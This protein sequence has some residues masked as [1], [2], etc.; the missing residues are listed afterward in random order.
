MPVPVRKQIK[1]YIA[2]NPFA[3]ATAAELVTECA[4]NG[5]RERRVDR[6][7]AR[8]VANNV[9]TKSGDDYTIT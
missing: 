2:A 4:E 9:L 1:D 3:T 6:V 5:V 7:L 8:L